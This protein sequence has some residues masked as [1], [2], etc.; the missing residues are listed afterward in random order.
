MGGRNGGPL[1]PRGGLHPDSRLILVTAT[2][3]AVLSFHQENTHPEQKTEQRIPA[4]PELGSRVP[5]KGLKEAELR[6]WLHEPTSPPSA[7]VPGALTTDHAQ[8][9]A[10]G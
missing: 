4:P 7:K 6:T 1:G 10:L 2:P 5:E 9:P 3:H 8:V